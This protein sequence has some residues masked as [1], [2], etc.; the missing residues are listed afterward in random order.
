MQNEANSEYPDAHAD[1]KQALYSK[2]SRTQ[3]VTDTRSYFE[4]QEFDAGDPKNQ[5]HG[6]L[7]ARTSDPRRRQNPKRKDRPQ[8]YGSLISEGVPYFG[9]CP[10]VRPLHARRPVVR[11]GMSSPV[12][13]QSHAARQ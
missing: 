7:D 12:Q 3:A 2:V 8:E 1:A 11:I 4:S 6:S 10:F 9:Q 5:C 13:H